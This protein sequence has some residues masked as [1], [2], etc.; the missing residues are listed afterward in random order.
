VHRLCTD[1]A[2][3]RDRVASLERGQQG[4]PMWEAAA[5]P[6]PKSTSALPLRAEGELCH[7]AEP[8]PERST[9]FDYD[10]AS[11][12]VPHVDAVQPHPAHV[13]CPEPPHARPAAGHARPSGLARQAR[14]PAAS[15]T[16]DSA[17]VPDGLRSRARDGQVVA[18]EDLG[19]CLWQSVQDSAPQDASRQNVV[20]PMHPTR[21]PAAD[22]HLT[23]RHAAVP[24]LIRSSSPQG[25][26]V[27]ARLSRRQGVVETHKF[28]EGRSPLRASGRAARPSSCAV[29]SL[30]KLAYPP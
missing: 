21:I 12:A 7:L 8:A 15:S 17:G 13:R 14:P 30:P 26:V 4:Q 27:T 29:Q 24:A 5:R 25:A 3:Q 19:D 28:D 10:R 1:C 20:P 2:R 18:D 16:A 22:Q 11:S 6:P 23:A 9:E